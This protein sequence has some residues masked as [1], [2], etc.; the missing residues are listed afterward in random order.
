MLPILSQLERQLDIPIV[1]VSCPGDI[2]GPQEECTNDTFAEGKADFGRMCSPSYVR[3][4]SI[5]LPLVIPIVE[6]SMTHSSILYVRN[7]SNY[8]N[9]FDLQNSIFAFNDENSLSGFHC[10]RF[11][12]KVY[13]DLNPSVSLPFFS[14]V[15]RSGSH[16]NSVNAVVN[17]TAD[18]L[19]LDSNVLLEMLSTSK[20]KELLSHLRTISLPS[21]TSGNSCI[22][23]EGVLGPN[24][25]QPVV[26]SKRLSNDLISKIKIAFDNIDFSSIPMSPFQR[27]E[28]VSCNFYDHVSFMIEECKD[29]SILA[30]NNSYE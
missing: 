21:L 20:G 1:F 30:A 2:S 14:T 8:S 13:A 4:S 16:I 26:V 12:L 18:C 17:G 9:I 6:G 7:D 22:S 25:I 15:F 29:L 23:R 24:P 5:L 27:Y 11:F 28:P 10:L 3:A 19:I